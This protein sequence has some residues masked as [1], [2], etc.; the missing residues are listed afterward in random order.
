MGVAA[1]L[2]ADRRRDPLEGLGRGQ[3]VGPAGVDPRV[4]LV[5]HARDADHEEL[6][7]VRAVD[8]EELE[9]LHQGQ[10]VA[11]GELE[12]AVV[13]VEPRKL[14]IDVQA[15]VAQLR[16]ARIGMALARAAGRR[17]FDAFGGCH[18]RELLA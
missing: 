1:V 9:P 17:G 11:L 13:E 10:L 18:R 12:H 14:A 15:R 4:D 8:R 5:V 6:V 3:A 7:E 16:M 2:L